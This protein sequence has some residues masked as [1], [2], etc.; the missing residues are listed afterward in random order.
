M[1]NSQR[2]Q[3]RLSEIRS[4]LNE[5]AGLE[6]DAFT[7]DIR[8][9]SDRLSG[10]F[11]DKETQF[12]AAVIAEGEAETR[13]RE[14]AP[15]AEQRERLEL[16]SKARLTAFVEAAIAGRRVGGAELEL[17]QAAG[18]GDGQVP[19]ELWDVP[20]SEKRADAPTGAPGTVGVNLDPIR[21]AVFAQS[22]APMLGI[23]MPNVGSGTYATATI[24]QSL[25]AAA[26]GKGD[27]ADSTAAAFA[28]STAVPKRISA[29]MSIRIEDIAAIGVDNFE[30]ALRQNLSLVLSDELDKQ[31]I[32]GDGQGDNLTGILAR[33][34][35]PSAPTEVADFDAF[36]ASFAGGIDGLWASTLRDVA[37]VCGVDTYRLSAS[38]F[39]DRVIA[40]STAAA[41]SLGDQAFSDYAMDKYGGWWTNKRMPAAASDVQAGILYRK[42]RSMMGGSG[43]MRTAVC[44]TWNVLSIDDIYTGSGRGE[45]Y[46]TMHVLLGDVIL[47]QPDAYAQVAYKVS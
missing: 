45:R 42:G 32:A 18:V 24:N 20:G 29:R 36:V 40:E 9:E 2:L 8:T 15:D 33:L 10:E 30:S 26:K 39:R 5:I 38:T 22:I 11:K 43:M 25:T 21:P 28:L 44:P 19:L 14:A 17:L 6:G 34:T 12:R 23:D 47:V 41:A 37:I 27:D 4:R 13:A 3:V 46:L 31:G 16:R 1:T 35:D 7:D